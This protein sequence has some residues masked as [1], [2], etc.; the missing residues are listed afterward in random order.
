LSLK[1]DRTGLQFTKKWFRDRNQGTF[2]EYVHPKFEGLP[3]TYL[4]IGVFEGMS[5]CWMIQHILTHP[6][7]KAV[8][9]DPWLGMKKLNSEEMEKVQGRAFHN[10]ATK[11]S[12]RQIASV[13]ESHKLVSS[14]C[15]LFRLD[16]D[17]FLTHSEHYA[18]ITK[19]SVDIIMIDGNHSAPF[20]ANDA[21]KAFPLLKPEGWL[22]FDDVENDHKKTY[23]VKDGIQMFLNHLKS[24]GKLLTLQLIWKHGYMECFE[25]LE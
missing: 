2:S 17:E 22:L 4:E 14:K 15:S 10:V 25:K 12:S 1:L 8:G 3:I 24:Q 20:V 11:L 13:R 18:G 6:D 5:M 23:H 9:V 19:E 16:S 7:S 21:I